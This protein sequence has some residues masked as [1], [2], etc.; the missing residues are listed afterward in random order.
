MELL[1]QDKINS[2]AADAL[3]GH[4]MDRPDQSAH[5]LA[6]IHNLLQVSDIGTLEAMV[7]Q[8]ITDPDNA[9]AVADIRGGKDKAIGALVGRIMKMSKGKANPKMVQDLIRARIS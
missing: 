2:S 8:V 6:S 1:A 3:F 4:C 9:R 5:E 7:D